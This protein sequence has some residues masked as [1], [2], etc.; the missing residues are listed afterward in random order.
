MVIVLK[1]A[2][3]MIR[4]TQRK[5]NTVKILMVTIVVVLIVK[6]AVLQG[7]LHLASAIQKPTDVNTILV[8]VDVLMV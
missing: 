4:G 7:V 2:I 6:V 1:N 3:V 8:Q 5:L